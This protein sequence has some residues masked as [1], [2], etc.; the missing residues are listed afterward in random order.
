MDDIQ[1]KSEKLINTPMHKNAKELLQEN[2]NDYSVSLIYQS[3]F[4]AFNDGAD[5]V[6][7]NHVKSAITN[8]GKNKNK[9]WGR[10]LLKI[11]G[12]TFFGI[13]IPGFISSIDPL[14]VLLLIIYTILGF[15][16]IFLVFIGISDRR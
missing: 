1:S 15:T 13:F 7:S 11:I 5:E 8:I 16:G 9:N 3:K 2:I 12:G 4:E 10:E 14:N 6:Q